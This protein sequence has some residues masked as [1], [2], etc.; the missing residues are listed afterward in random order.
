MAGFPGLLTVLGGLLTVPD[1]E[2][3]IFRCLGA[4]FGANRVGQGLS[5]G[6]IPTFIPGLTGV[7][8]GLQQWLYRAVLGCFGS[9]LRVSLRVFW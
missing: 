2:D 5:S 7:V 1:S 3:D 4:Y 6:T 8:L 9:V